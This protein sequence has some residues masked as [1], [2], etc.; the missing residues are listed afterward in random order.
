MTTA[1][2]RS[3]AEGEACGQGGNAPGCKTLLAFVR[4]S[5]RGATRRFALTNAVRERSH[6]LQRPVGRCGGQGRARSGGLFFFREALYQLS[7]LT[8]TT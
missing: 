4:A 1:R 8:A 6:I 2:P 7:Y 5:Q 3:G